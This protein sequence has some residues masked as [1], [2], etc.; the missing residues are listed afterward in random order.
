MAY[1]EPLEELVV[2]LESLP[3][4]GR[5]TAE[6]LAFHLLRDPAA[7]TL[8]RAIDRALADTKHCQECC[9]VTKTSPCGICSDERRTRDSILVVEEPRDVEAVERSGAWSGLY[10]VLF[11]A[12][13]PSDGT[14]EAHLSIP[15]L[16]KRVQTGQIR[17]LILGT[18][19]DAEGEATALCVLEAVERIES[20]VRVTRMAR[21]LPAGS[22]IEY[23]H[24]GVLE[25]ALE[26]RRSI[27]QRR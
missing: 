17:E 7:S 8:S 3:G 6:R 22:A 15:Q 4:I 26:G 5:R 25:D 9:N 14:E 16:M 21:G 10:H 24:R 12:L 11:G 19:P 2:R 18:D 13:N 27:R 20:S 23:L 1:P